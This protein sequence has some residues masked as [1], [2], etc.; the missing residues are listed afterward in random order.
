MLSVRKQPGM[1]RSSKLGQLIFPIILHSYGGEICVRLAPCLSG[2]TDQYR[3]L[4][5]WNN[6]KVD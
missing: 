5:K 3:C 4:G 6:Y 2:S 1:P